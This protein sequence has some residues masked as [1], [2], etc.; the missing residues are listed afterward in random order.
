M[1]SK[2][3]GACGSIMS[4]SKE[5]N[6]VACEVCGKVAYKDNQSYIILGPVSRATPTYIR[7]SIRHKAKKRRAPL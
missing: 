1:A 7:I 6:E 3:C 4:F 2:I 5:E